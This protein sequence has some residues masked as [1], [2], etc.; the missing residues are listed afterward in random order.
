MDLWIDGDNMEEMH[1]RNINR[2]Y[3]K[4]RVWID[5]IDFYVRTCNIFRNFPFELKKVASQAISSSDSI[6][7]NIAEGYCRKTIKEYINFLTIAKGSLGESISGIHAYKK[8]GQIDQSDFE[9]LDSLAFKLEN[10]LLKLIE[11]L[12]KKEKEGTWN[13]SILIRESNSLY[14]SSQISS[15]PIIQGTVINYEVIIM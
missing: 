4:L 1:R 13:Q 6:H 3:M 15:N 7:R 5:S 2:G 14:S 8:A 11:S 12:E 9:E 10:G